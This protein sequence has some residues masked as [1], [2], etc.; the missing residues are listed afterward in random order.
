MYN[1]KT[2]S[3]HV[4]MY[5]SYGTDLTAYSTFTPVTNGLDSDRVIS[6]GYFL[7]YLC[8]VTSNNL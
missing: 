5:I 1:P 7:W 2:L 8:Q 6:L 4:S 3:F